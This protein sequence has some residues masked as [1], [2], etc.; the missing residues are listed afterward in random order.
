MSWFQLDPESVAERVRASGRTV[1]TPCVWTSLQRGIVG[2]TIL[3]VAGFVPWAVF[4]RGFYRTIGEGG[5]YAVCALVFIGLSGP[6]MHRLILGPGS[7]SRFYKLFAVTFAANSILW[8]AGW[9]ALRKFWHGHLGSLAGLVA[10]NAAMG[11]LLILAFD[12]K[13]LALKVIAALFVLNA[14]GYFVGGWIEGS[15]IGMKQVSLFGN[16]VAKPAQAMIA[17]LLWGVLYGIGFGAG[18]GLAFHSCQAHTRDVLRSLG[19]EQ[20]IV[21]IS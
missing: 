5:L 12:A 20:K 18:L 1:E 19:P 14:I 17:K 15:V 6:L 11:W 21:V 8:I 13:G 4:G 16:A 7:L 10:G 3:S 2:F 9:F